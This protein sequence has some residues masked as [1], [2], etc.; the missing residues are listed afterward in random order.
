MTPAP[1]GWPYQAELKGRLKRKNLQH[2]TATICDGPNEHLA[3]AAMPFGHLSSPALWAGTGA[4]NRGSRACG[5]IIERGESNN[6]SIHPA[7][8]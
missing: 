2:V 6:I 1:I 3:P 5:L 4:G 8:R 7:R